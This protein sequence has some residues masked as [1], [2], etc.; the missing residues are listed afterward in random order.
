MRTNY[1]KDG[2]NKTRP[3]RATKYIYYWKTDHY[4]KQHY[5]VFEHNLNSN[6]I[7]L[8]DESKVYLEAY[9]LGVRSVYIRQKKPGCKLVANVKKL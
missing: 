4:L 7:H 2:A 1:Q 6:Q 5:H 8:G 9:K 3:E